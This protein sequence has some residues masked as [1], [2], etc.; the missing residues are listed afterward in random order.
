LPEGGEINNGEQMRRVIIYY[1]VKQ[2]CNCLDRN[3]VI[4]YDGFDKSK[5]K[6]ALNNPP[7]GYEARDE[8]EAY[9]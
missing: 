2:N 1:C 3:G 9:R 6:K 5:A 7:S 4:A 8:S